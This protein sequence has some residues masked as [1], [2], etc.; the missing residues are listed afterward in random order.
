MNLFINLLKKRRTQYVLGKDLSHDKDYLTRLIQE[1]IKQGPSAFNSQSS[2]AVILYDKEGEVFWDMVK[3]TLKPLVS[4]ENFAATDAK[5][6]GFKKGVGTILFYEDEL[7]IQELQEQFSLYADNFPVWSEHSTGI[8]QMAVWTA[9][10]SENIGASL[11]HYNPLIDEEVANNW[12]IPSHWKL[13][14]QM[15]F[16]SHEADIP[17]KSFMDDEERFFVY[18]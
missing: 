1:A 7:V 5:I 4:V 6:E 18:H 8:A 17:E 12:K 9:L 16:G 11:Q 13:R 3:D 10:A 15:P 14:A 2:R